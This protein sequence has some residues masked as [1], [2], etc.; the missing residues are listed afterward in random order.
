MATVKVILRED[1]INKKTNLAPLYIRIIK[2][3]KA[4]FISLGVKVEP[5]YW[6][7]EKSS[8][9]KGAENYKEINNFILHKRSE[10]EKTSLELESMSNDVT[11]TLITKNL[12]RHKP[13]NFFEYADKK[14]EEMKNKR[15]YGTMEGY[16]WYLR[17]LEKFHGSRKLQFSDIDIHFV[18]RYEK[19]MYEELN[20]SAGTVISAFKIVK[21]MFNYAINEDLISPNLHPFR[22]YSLKKPK[23]TKT[24]L[25]EEQF[26]ALLNYDSKK[27]RKG[28]IY[29][30]MFIFS[31]Y[32]GGLRFSDVVELKWQDYLEN[33]SYVVKVIRK[34]QRKHQFK[35]PKKAVEIIDKYKTEEAK[36]TDYIFPLYIN[37]FD[38]NI[39]SEVQYKEKR[40][41]NK[42]ANHALNTIGK[43]LELPF[44]LSFH[45]SRHTFATRALNKGMRIEH[46]SK[47]MDHTDISVTQ[48]YAKILNK[49]LDKAM[50][51]MDD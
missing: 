14:M 50:D 19:Y 22:K 16:K 6:S 10:A 38:Y 42:L 44:S 39:S 37:G 3:R 4:K 27:L 8:V 43:E 2:D 30:D 47:I 35:L 24:Y 36:T 20:N 40:K 23:T 15:S 33:G 41:Y 21:L 18:Q 9:K 45:T 1:K 12:K 51:I 46:V 7:E 13:R 28:E 5:K 26:Q 32:A 25:N 31:C 34:T 11:S 29:Y 17:K 48:I 49:E